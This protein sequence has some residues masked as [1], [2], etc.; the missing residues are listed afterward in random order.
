MQLKENIIS[1]KLH[2][3]GYDFLDCNVYGTG[4]KFPCPLIPV[5]C[6]SARMSNCGYTLDTIEYQ[7]ITK[8]VPS[9]RMCG[10]HYCLALGW[11]YGVISSA[12]RRRLLGGSEDSYFSTDKWRHHTEPRRWGIFGQSRK[13][14]GWV[15]HYVAWAELLSST[16]E[17]NRVF[18]APTSRHPVAEMCCGDEVHRWK[19]Q[20]LTCMN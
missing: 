11:L 19:R 5:S 18:P 1:L 13:W 15:C 9:L 3:F 10:R 4:L 12:W 8:L 7:S 2:H 16:G 6:L 14:I 20:K 17:R